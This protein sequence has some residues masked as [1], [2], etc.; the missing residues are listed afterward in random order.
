MLLYYTFLFENWFSKSQTRLNVL[1]WYVHL[2]LRYT[3]SKKQTKLTPAVHIGNKS[4]TSACSFKQI[5]CLTDPQPVRF[6][7]ACSGGDSEHKNLQLYACSLHLFF[8]CVFFSVLKNNQ[9]VKLNLTDWSLNLIHELLIS[10]QK[11]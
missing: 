9:S 10:A 3:E 11:S 1:A 6:L 7:Q 2:R 8:Y 5:R 4:F